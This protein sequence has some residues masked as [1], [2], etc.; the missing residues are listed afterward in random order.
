MTG[1]R[2][3]PGLLAL[4]GRLEPPAAARDPAYSGGCEK[5][6]GSE[7]DLD[8]EPLIHD[9]RSSTEVAAVTLVPLAT[10][11]AHSSGVKLGL[12]AIASLQKRDAQAVGR[13]DL[14]ETAAGLRAHG[15]TGYLFRVLPGKSLRRKDQILTRAPKRAVPHRP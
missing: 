11:R 8:R 1:L 10:T 2:F 7:P 9:G 4:A 13:P 14:A 12:S 6:R 3:E 5:R 15:Q